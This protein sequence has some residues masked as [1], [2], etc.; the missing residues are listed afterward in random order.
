M[1]ALDIS[2]GRD[3]QYTVG[4]ALAFAGDFSRS[5]ALADDLEK[6]FPEDT[7]VKYTYAPVLRALAAL[8]R[9]NPSASVEQLQV[10][11]P[12]ELAANGLNFNHVLGGLYSAYVRGEAYVAA[13]EY[14][15]GAAEFRLDMPELIDRVWDVRD[16]IADQRRKRGD[17]D[18]IMLADYVSWSCSPRVNEENGA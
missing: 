9:G 4:L 14:A 18:R 12:Y 13:H 7:F 16:A 5:E 1:A 3:V 11:V 15:R 8:A 2:K 17:N 6:R 10:A